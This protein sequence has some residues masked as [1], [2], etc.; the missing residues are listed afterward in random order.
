MNVF[1][2]EDLLRLDSQ[3]RAELA[4]WRPSGSPACP[5]CGQLSVRGHTQGAGTQGPGRRQQR[6][7]AQW[8][9]K[10]KESVP[11][12]RALLV[13]DAQSLRTSIFGRNCR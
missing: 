13:S 11:L 7:R 2:A 12:N 10:R 8:N 3:H 9:R 4:A 6:S 5:R 1:G